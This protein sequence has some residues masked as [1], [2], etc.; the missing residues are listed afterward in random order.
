[1]TLL[2]LLLGFLTKV[3][4]IIA[5]GAIVLEFLYS[6]RQQIIADK[7]V[8]IKYVSRIVIFLAFFVALL[9]TLHFVYPFDLSSASKYWRH[10]FVLSGRN[11]LQ[12]T[13]QFLKALFYISPLFL[14]SLLFIS[15]KNFEKLR[16]FLV[17]LV[18][19][20]FFYLVL[21]DFSS[22]ALDRY[23]QF[24]IVPLSI[25]LGVTVADIFGS[26]GTYNKKI[27]ILTGCLIA[28]GIF[29]VQ[30]LHQFVPALYPKT[31]WFSRVVG[32]KWNFLF[33]FTGGSGPAGFY[34]SWLFISLVW[35]ATIAL[36]IVAFV[37]PRLLK[38]VWV[39]ILILG[40]LYGGV[41]TEEYLFGRINRTYWK[42]C[43]S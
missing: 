12:V 31:A 30:F 39:V 26:E 2:F 13:I 32:L 41:F 10:F 33:P 40:F 6:R 7:K 36:A 29:L 21:F 24:I 16:L 23:M 25:I 11:Y 35:M 27:Y 42:H 22:G 9:A 3:S 14:V 17:F 1:M 15:K 28:G 19:G 43:H 34:V 5:A 8:L 18:L 20:L 37:K 38:P 4:F